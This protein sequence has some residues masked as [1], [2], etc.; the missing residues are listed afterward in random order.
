M[1]VESKERVWSHHGSTVYVWTE[2]ELERVWL[3]IVEGQSAG[4]GET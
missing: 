2:R 4:K 1:I 3:Y